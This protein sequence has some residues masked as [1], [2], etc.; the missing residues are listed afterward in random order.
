MNICMELMRSIRFM[1]ELDAVL[2]FSEIYHQ[3]WYPPPPPAGDPAPAPRW[4]L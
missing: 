3:H 4:I 1:V 2:W